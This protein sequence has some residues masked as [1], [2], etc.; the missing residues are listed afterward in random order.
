MKSTMAKPVEKT[1]S[2]EDRSNPWLNQLGV[3]K[4]LAVDDN[5]FERVLL[6]SVLEAVKEYSVLAVPDGQSAL[7]LAAQSPP[8]AVIL[9][10]KLLGMSGLEVLIELKKSHPTLPIIILTGATDVRTAVEAIKAGAHNYLTKPFENDQL[11][12]ILRQAIERNELITQM[13]GLTRK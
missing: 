5:P 3:K 8:D 9:D 2:A 1:V 4:I 10:L 11:L 12:L 13:E 7:D 6:E